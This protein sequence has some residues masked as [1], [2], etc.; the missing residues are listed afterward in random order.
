MHTKVQR[1]RIKEVREKAKVQSA[2][3]LFAGAINPDQNGGNDQ[4]GRRDDLHQSMAPR[5]EPARLRQ[6]RQSHRCTWCLG[7]RHFA[8]HGNLHARSPRCACF[9]RADLR[10]KARQQGK[11]GQE[12]AV[13][14]AV[15]IK[16]PS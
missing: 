13:D 3:P 9:G 11:Q 16:E 2:R 14:H 1:G 15:Q 10:G 6:S 8:Q 12:Q 5:V 7:R 4:R